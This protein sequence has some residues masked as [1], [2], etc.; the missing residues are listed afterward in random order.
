MNSDRGEEL[1]ERPRVMAAVWGPGS[2]ATALAMLDEAGQLVAF[3]F[4]GA[5]SGPLRAPHPNDPP[6]FHE[7][8]RKARAPFLHALSQRPLF[9]RFMLLWLLLR[10]SCIWSVWRRLH[11]CAEIDLCWSHGCLVLR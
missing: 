10:F 2:P 6:L 1:V 5:L 7:A 11:V 8:N 3:M 9:Q 4:A